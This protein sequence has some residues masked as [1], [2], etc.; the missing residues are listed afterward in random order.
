MGPRPLTQPPDRGSEAIGGGPGTERSTNELQLADADRPATSRRGPAPV[1]KVRRSDWDLAVVI[2]DA[3]AVLRTPGAGLPEVA[4]AGRS[5]TG[6]SSLINAL[7]RRKGL[8]RTS[9]TPGRT[10][11]ILVF[12]GPGKTALADLP[13]YG[14]ARAPQG[15]RVQWAQLIDAYIAQRE[16]LAGLL[17]IVDARRGLGPLDEE[18]LARIEARGLP[19]R[20]ITTKVDKLTRT[21]KDRLPQLLGPRGCNAI[22]FSAKTGEGREDVW[23]AVA[24]LAALR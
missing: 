6:K 12:A 18:M 11:E 23:R 2:P 14:W 21:E 9:S 4:L 5:N 8:A 24:E 3:T 17:L 20:L 7:V 15:A 22:F 10:Q 1:V 13:G 16:M 19:W